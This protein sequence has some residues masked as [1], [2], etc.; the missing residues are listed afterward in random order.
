MY[1]IIYSEDG[2]STV[3][4][5]V[6]F[7]AHCTLILLNKMSLDKESSTARTLVLNFLKILKKYQDKRYYGDS[8]MHRM[9]HRIMQLLLLI[10]PALDPLT[11]RELHDT[12]SELII[13][14]SNQPT[15]RIMQE[16]LLIK[17]YNDN[18]TMQKDIWQL[19]EMAKEKRPGSIVSIASIIY[20]VSRI[21][22]ELSK[23]SYIEKAIENLLPC[24]F[25]QQFVVRLYCQ[26]IL[27]KI[28][29]MLRL[30]DYLLPKHQVI[31]RAVQESMRYGNLKKNSTKL[32]DDFYFTIFHPIGDYNLQV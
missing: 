11:T 13:M 17:I 20:H 12:I 8:T 7:R 16:W 15:V 18:P 30:E 2:V 4:I 21:L 27:S 1:F 10:Q 32:I 9:K 5:D 6:I 14:E 3:Y 28:F 29:V 25:S 26:V 22:P 24:C 19:L 23:N 31:E